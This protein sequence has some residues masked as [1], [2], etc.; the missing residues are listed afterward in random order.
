MVDEAGKRGFCLFSLHLKGVNMLNKLFKSIIKHKGDLS[1]VEER[2]E[3]GNFAA[4]IGIISNLVLFT[5]KY[6]VGVISMSISIQT[7]AI[8]NLFDSV[9]SLLALIGFKVA[10]KPADNNHPFGH[11]RFELIVDLFVGMINVFVGL[12][13]AITSFNKIVDKSEII[14]SKTTVILLIFTLFIKLWQSMFNRQIAKKIDSSLL[15]STAQDSLNDAL[16]N[17]IILVGLFIQVNFKL[18]IDGLM[19]IIL[20]GYI[21][22]SGTRSILETINDLLGKK[23]DKK[24]F[25]EI[26]QY[27]LT[28]EKILGYH[29]LII[30][31][32]GPSKAYASV[33]IEVESTLD[34]LT[35]HK[36]ADQI[37]CGFNDLFDVN[38]VVHIDPVD[39]SD[40]KRNEYE[41]VV[42]NIVSMYDNSYSIHDFRLFKHKGLY[43]IKFDLVVFSELS[44]NEIVKAI[45]KE[46]RKHYQE[47]TID[48]TVDRHY[49]ELGREK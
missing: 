25:L 3:Y 42:K 17:L 5:I 33:H 38:L 21:I 8:N 20:S 2:Y 1:K 31:Y 41:S 22:M 12:S 37:E 11:A 7:D 9:S 4:I 14:M 30:H 16:V 40:P 45:K 36:I 27:F 6:G 46:I 29:D 39:L 44:D 18:Q 19:G 15:F 34:L 13:F 24:Q 32:Y 28:F 35:A 48:I 26:E 43:T 47:E 23:V 49:I 10:R